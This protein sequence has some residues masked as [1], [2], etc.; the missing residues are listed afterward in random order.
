MEWR[1]LGEKAGVCR[2]FGLVSSM[3]QTIWK[4]GTQIISVFKKKQQKTDTVPVSRLFV[5]LILCSLNFNFKLMHFQRK[6]VYEF[7]IIED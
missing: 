3:V 5:M 4:N 1:G 6:P 7:A 2:K